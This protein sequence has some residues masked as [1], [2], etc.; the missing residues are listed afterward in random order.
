MRVKSLLC[1]FFLLLMAG[2]VFAQV[3]TG[4]AYP[5][6]E[7]RAAWIQSVNGQFRGMP[8]EKLKQNLIGQLNSLQKAGINAIIFQVR[9]EADALYAS[10]LEP[11]SR[12][13][14]GVQGKAPEPY[15]DPMQFMIDECHKRGMEFHAWINPYRTKTTLKSELAPNHVYN[16]HPEW[17]VTYGDQLY[18]DPALPESR[19]HICMVVSDIVSRYDVDA[20]HMDDY[21][22]PYPIKG[23]DFP[24]DASFAR[25]GG[26][27]S[28]KGDWRRSNVN[29]LI[30]KLHETIREIKPWVKFG[31]SPFGIYRNESSDPLG[32]KTKGLQNYDD[33]YADV[34]LWAREG[35]IDYNIPQIY[36]HIGHPVADYE[37]LV[38]WWAKNTENR[39]L[40]IGQSVMNTVQNADPKN[41]SINQLPRKMALQ[42]AY[43][44][45]GG[46]CQWPASAV[47][48]NAGK[49]R[50]ALIAE[51]HKYLALPPVF[52]FMDNEAPGKVRKMKPIWTEDGYILFWTAP[53]YK[54]EMNRAVQYVVYRF[55]DK[56]KVNIDD[57]SH[58][59]AIT[60]DNFYKLPYEDGKT[61]YR[62]V[63]TALDRLHNESKSVGKKIKL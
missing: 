23:K 11:W 19:R 55:N 21:F 39:P 63:V 42:R 34:L 38:K 12:F 6:R 1:V 43:Q 57:P 4:S 37:T 32:S 56:E 46:S 31:V 2:G 53:K 22:Y 59:V 20:I 36:W 29:V 25:F 33:L 58:I 27:F 54:E 49:Y 30:K 13:L 26:G 50:D 61:K 16:I 35:W 60:R 41:P 51:Y 7:F 9:P 45:I 17:F 8:T 40:F 48:E 18:F 3:Q 10:R 14:T 52:D 47:I 62:Y 15:W 44:T 24:D 5:K 28:N